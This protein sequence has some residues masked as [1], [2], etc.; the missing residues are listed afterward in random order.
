FESHPSHSVAGTPASDESRVSHP[1][2]RSIGVSDAA[3]DVSFQHI[4]ER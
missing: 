4:V 1:E 2:R 3:L